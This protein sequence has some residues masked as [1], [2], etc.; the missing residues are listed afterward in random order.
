V[1]IAFGITVPA[2]LGD[3]LILQAVR[4]TGGTALAVGD[5]EILHEVRRCAGLEGLFVC[6]EGAAA[7]AAVRRLRSS[8]WLDAAEEIVVLNTGSGLKYPETISQTSRVLKAGEEIP[9]GV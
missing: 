9:G 2:P 7:L 3:F 8:G 6:P 5:E 4:A 1:T